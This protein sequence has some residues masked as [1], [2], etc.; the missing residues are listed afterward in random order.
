MNGLKWSALALAL[1]AALAVGWW[2]GR[3]SAPAASPTETEASEPVERKILYYRN[4][5]GL[6]DTSPVPKKDSMGMDYLPVFADEA[7]PPEP[8]TVVLAPG[9]VQ[10]LGVRTEAAVR[11]ALAP[12][13]RA[14]ATVEV[15][16]TRQFA[17]APR[18]E[19]WI[20]TLHANQT[21][22]A[23]RRGDALATVYSPELVAARQEFRVADDAAKRLAASDPDSAATMRQLRDAART[24]LRN[25]EVSGAGVARAGSESGLVLSSPTDAVVVEKLVVQGERFEP[26]QTILRLADLSRVWVVAQ[27]PASGLANLTLGDHASFETPSLP[28]R[29]FEGDVAFIQPTLDRASRTLGVRIEVENPDGVLRPGLFGDV[30]LTGQASAPVVTVDRSAVIDS[31][32]RQVVLVQTAPGQFTPRE[33]QLGARSGDR[34]AVLSGVEAG[35]TVVVSANFLLDAESNLRAALGSLEAGGARE[36]AAPA[37]APADDS[38]AGHGEPSDEPPAGHEAPA[39]DPHAGHKGGH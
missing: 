7:P 10:Q 39:D 31:G 6:P 5:M 26:G 19:G 16:E 21:G 4:P 14:S 18:F 25:W 35:E 12:R 8:G 1:G 15:D 13:V 30:E 34:V 11:E 23:I 24:R 27:V 38:H 22:M 20:E 36:T 37:D 9:K 29:R 32:T 33:V 17:V 28:G 2:S 3:A